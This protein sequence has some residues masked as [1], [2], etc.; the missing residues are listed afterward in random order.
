VKFVDA[1]QVARL[2]SPRG[3]VDAIE[4]ALRGPFDPSADPARIQ[5]PLSHGEFLIMP[6]EAAG[7]AGVKIATVA[8][9]NPSLS[10]PRIQAT[11]VLFDSATLAPVAIIDGV[12]LTSLRTA[13]V[14]LAAV[15][16]FVERLGDALTV[17]VFGAGPQAIAHLAALGDCLAPGQTI[18]GVTTVVRHPDG[19]QVGAGSSDADTALAHADIVICAT[20]ARKPLFDSNLVKDRTVVIAVGS[21]EPDARELDAALLGRSHV[22]VEDAATALREAGD[23]IQAVAARAV[24]PDDLIP[25]KSADPAA[26]PFDRPVVFKST[27]MSWEDLVIASAIYRAL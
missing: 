23:V 9:G 7:F 16:P 25:M 20:T 19:D 17:V 13:A 12:A 11:Y 6:S 14:S 4:A 8:P 18:A 15:R 21:H 2:L 24:R 5:T 27:G 3:A 22:L 26:I 1:G 10:L